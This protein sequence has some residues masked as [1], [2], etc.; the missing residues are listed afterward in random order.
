MEDE[1]FIRKQIQKILNER[2]PRRRRG[3]P[4]SDRGSPGVRRVPLE[5]GALAQENPREL[6]RKL[7]I[8]SASGNTSQEKVLS[9]L[10]SA[11][12]TLRS[13]DELKDAFSGVSDEGDYIMIQKGDIPTSEAVKY[14]NHILI[15]AEEAGVLSRLDKPVIATEKDGEAVVLFE[16]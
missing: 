12:S 4:G 14:V 3:S 6:I 13:N 11:I 8:R 10:T 7:N 1:K 2:N 5:Q 15:A 16:A 9:V